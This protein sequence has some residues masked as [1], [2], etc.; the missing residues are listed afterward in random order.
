MPETDTKKLLL[1]GVECQNQEERCIILYITAE[2]YKQIK[3]PCTYVDNQ[4]LSLKNKINLLD[5]VLTSSED[6]NSISP[7]PARYI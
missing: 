7:L 5:T 4:N 6:A 3:L 2:Q 1:N